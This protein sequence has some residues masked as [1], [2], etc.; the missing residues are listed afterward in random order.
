M[1]LRQIQLSRTAFSPLSILSH[2]S[3]KTETM[4][5]TRDEFHDGERLEMGGS[6]ETGKSLAGGIGSRVI[7]LP[8]A[9]EDRHDL[10]KT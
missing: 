4:S 6:G 3:R 7:H 5:G 9:Q 8:L 10:Q 2:N 1:G